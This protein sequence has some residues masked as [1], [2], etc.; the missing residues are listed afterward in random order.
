MKIFKT[1]F[2]LIFT[3]FVQLETFKIEDIFYEKLE[4]D[5]HK[6]T[7]TKIVNP[8]VD[9]KQCRLS[10]VDSDNI[11]HFEFPS[12]I[13]PKGTEEAEMLTKFN[14]HYEYLTEGDG[15]V[16]PRG[17]AETQTNL[18]YFKPKSTNTEIQND[19]KMTN[20]RNFDIYDT[21]H[22]SGKE[23]ISTNKTLTDIKSLSENKNFFNLVLV[24]ERFMAENYSRQQMKMYKDMITKPASQQAENSFNLHHLWTLHRPEDQNLHV[25]SM[26]WSDELVAV[27]YGN[28][29]AVDDQDDANFCG[30]VAV[31]NFKNSVNPERKYKFQVSVCDVEFSTLNRQNLAISFNDGSL[32]ILDITEFTPISDQNIPIIAQTDENTK[33]N[34]AA[35]LRI[36]WIEMGGE[37]F[38]FAASIDGSVI[39]YQIGSGGKMSGSRHISILRVEGPVEGLTNVEHK[40][41][42]VESERYAKVLSMEQHPKRLSEFMIGTDEGCVYTCSTVF[43]NKCLAQIQAQEHGIYSIDFSPFMSNVFLTA[44]IDHKI[45]IW[46]EDVL[47]PLMEF[48]ERF[49]SFQCVKFSKIHPTIFMSCSHDG[50]RIWDLN[51]KASKPILVKNFTFKPTIFDFSPSGTS[52]LIGDMNGNVHVFYLYDSTPHPPQFGVKKL[53]NAIYD[54]LKR[55]EKVAT[56]S[57]VKKIMKAQTR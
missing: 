29:V 14:K 38:I 26:S 45:R 21:I 40:K 9:K 57:Q 31:W 42:F 7:K 35:I 41:N 32:K 55:R 23:E 15:K 19:D 22:S 5:E 25:V 13:E 52:I 44:G 28:F 16:R 17:E 20:V 47:E 53:Q 18:V 1:I 50:V 34:S 8:H 56:L 12:E 11:D 33:K 48:G 2:E 51:Q 30:L 54:A 4:I 36:K 6:I 10:L 49:T 39:K 37:E 24:V 43:I 3:I 27:G 46:M